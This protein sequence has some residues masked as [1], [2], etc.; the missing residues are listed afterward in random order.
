MDKSLG[1]MI[2]EV[3]AVNTEEERKQAEAE[4]KSYEAEKRAWQEAKWKAESEAR[5]EAE[6]A[7]KIEEKL[8]ET[9]NRI[10][11]VIQAILSLADIPAAGFVLFFFA[12]LASRGNGI[13][14]FATFILFVAIIGGIVMFIRYIILAIKGE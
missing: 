2:Q 9:S 13:P 11:R 4:Q 12:L 8:K 1:K 14:R 10:K 6:K 5:E 3:R 7:R